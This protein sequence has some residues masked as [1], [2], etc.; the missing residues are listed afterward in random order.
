MHIYTVCPSQ[1]LSNYKKFCWAVSVE[2]R[3]RTVLSTGVVTLILVK[4]LSSKRGITPRKIIESELPV[5]MHIYTLSPS[6]LQSFR[7]FCY[8]VSEELHWQPVLSSI[9]HLGQI[10]KLK[11]GLTR[12]KKN[13]SKLPVDMHIYMV[14]PSQIQSFTKFC[15]GVSEE[16]GCHTV[17]VIYFILAKFQ[18]SKTA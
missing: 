18:S 5:N 7:K 3:W 8:A 13:E 16:M 9:F 6:L 4:F 14:C 2:L 10:S 15:W 12:R 11:K 1:L 17:S